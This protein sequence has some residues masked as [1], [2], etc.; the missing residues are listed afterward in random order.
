ML[1]QVELELETYSFGKERMQKSIA[2]NEEKGGADNNP[3]AQAVYRR[4]VLPLADVIRAE[5]QADRGRGRK[6]AHLNL[7]GTVDPEPSAFVAVRAALVHL[8][9][10]TADNARILFSSV[11]AAVYHEL[12]LRDFDTL[13]PKLFH[14]LANGAGRN[15]RAGE[16]YRLEVFK[17]EGARKGVV[18]PE[19]E[20]E[21][22]ERV[23]VWFADQLATLGMLTIATRQLSNKHRTMESALSAEAATLIE[24]IRDRVVENSPYFLP[25]V[26]KPKDWASYDEGG[27]H[28]DQMR[29]LMPYAIKTHAGV[30]H[31]L[32]GADLSKELA[33]LNT[34]QA[35]KWR[36]NRR[37]LS[38]MLSMGGKINLGEVLAQ[39]EEPRPDRPAWLV[40][41]MEVSQMDADQ[42]REFRMWKRLTALWYA[43]RKKRVTK[44]GRYRQAMDVATRFADYEHLYFVYF[45]DF[46]GRK[47]AMTTGVSPQGS[48]LQKALLEFAE[49]KPLHTKGAKDWFCITGANRYGYDK[50]DLGGR[51]D[52]VHEHREFILSAARDPANSEWWLRA[53]KPLQFLAWCMEYSDWQEQG[54]SFESHLSAGMDGSCNGLQN[55]SA[56]LRDEVG[57]EATNLVAMPQP[58]DIYGRVGQVT[59]QLLLQ[60]PADPEGYR[61]RWLA[62]GINRSIVKRSVNNP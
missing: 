1:S 44:W 23:G 61:D 45:C 37:I 29:R 10:N 39:G 22:I 40:D 30:R 2:R 17:S 26:E 34:L 32:A 35:T 15:M 27:W 3:Y 47:Y 9:G 56:M 12:L 4:F 54:E 41:K 31:L 55:F 13:D 62:H 42:L 33:C 14:S 8:M 7:L 25:C 46:R 53:S 52:W 18:L 59:E 48:D 11:G 16:R 38:A 57:G 43:R 51:I 28:T 60:V 5:Q 24:G 6:P 36:I 50:V 58:Q 19:W 49:G 20:M 21:D